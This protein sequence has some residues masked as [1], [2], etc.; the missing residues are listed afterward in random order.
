MEI[1]S[2]NP[3]IM[4]QFAA[5]HAT[6]RNARKQAGNFGAMLESTEE[7]TEQE[8]TGQA[9]GNG[10]TEAE[11]DPDYRKFLR[12][13]MEEMRA[14]IKNGTIQPK[15]Q[16]GAEAYTQEEWQKLL[17]KID[18]AEEVLREQIEAEIE[19]AREA[20]EEEEAASD[21]RIITRPDGARILV[22]S[23]SFGEMSVQ[24]SEPD[25]SAAFSN[26]STVCDGEEAELLL[27][28]QEC[29]ELRIP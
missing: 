1:G 8:K 16:I 23:T 26:D 29:A 4:E 9:A 5:R 15:I 19:M 22:I 3:F 20:A 6:S 13:K 24:L 2:R 18:T 21:T 27:T 11:S 17:E 12:E 25:D 7:A 28:G 14:N 10:S